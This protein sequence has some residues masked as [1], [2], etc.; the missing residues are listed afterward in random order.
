M[1]HVMNE[2][3]QANVRYYNQIMLHK[4]NDD[5]SLIEFEQSPINVSYTAWPDHDKAVK[6]TWTN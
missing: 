2:N 1:R 5:C 6:Y 4:S 3:I